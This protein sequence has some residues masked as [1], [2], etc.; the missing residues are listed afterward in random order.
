MV[1]GNMGT[2]KKMNYTI[3]SNAVNLAARLE[4]VNKQYGTWI[5]ASENTIKATGNRL[6]CRQ[7]DRIRVVG[8]NEPVH[9]FEPMDFAADATSALREK[10]EMFHAALDI[11]EKRDWSAAEASFKKFLDIYP[12]D[13]PSM[14]HLERCQKFQQTEP[15]NDWDGVF[16][17]NE[18]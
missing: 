15:D 16:N 17:I 12:N 9:I 8:I 13:M 6:L 7:L 10:V 18:K 4:G 1:V 5:L 2:Q 11:F 3:I 14:I